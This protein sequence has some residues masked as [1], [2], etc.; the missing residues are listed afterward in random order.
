MEITIAGQTWMFLM[1]IVLGAALGVCYD[2]FRII[3][4]AVPNPP[5]VIL[6]EDVTFSLICAGAT[7]I[8]MIAVDCGEIRV[9]VLIGE[10]VGFALYYCTI[11]TLVIGAA[12]GIIAGIRWLLHMLWKIF[13]APVV[14]IIKKIAAFFTKRFQNMA[15]CLKN[16]AKKS[17]MHLKKPC[18][19]LYNLKKCNHGKRR[20]NN[21]K[22]QE[23]PN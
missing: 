9:F 13:I 19:I 23:Q 1:S 18:H 12:K 16:K 11:G 15:F 20:N 8:Y 21:V 14:R 17:N 2:V 6:V 5:A 10:V 7:L 22:E 3:R 4:I